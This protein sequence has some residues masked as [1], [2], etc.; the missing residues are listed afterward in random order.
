M[1]T[2]KKVLDLLKCLSDPVY[3]L[4]RREEFTKQIIKNGRKRV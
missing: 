2:L 4:K 3:A 1:L